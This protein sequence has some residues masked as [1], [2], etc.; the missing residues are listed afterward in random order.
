[1][2]APP[3]AGVPA[4]FNASRAQPWSVGQGE[5]CPGSRSVA[6]FSILEPAGAHLLMEGRTSTGKLDP[7]IGD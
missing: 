7:R 6:G 1:M 5:L 4:F 2:P 3:L